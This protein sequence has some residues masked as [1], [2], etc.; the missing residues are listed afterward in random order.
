MALIVS[1]GVCL[2]LCAVHCLFTLQ[3]QKLDSAKA[4]AQYRA[5]IMIHGV[6]MQT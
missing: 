2:C 4:I 1:D 3:E 5:P 6:T